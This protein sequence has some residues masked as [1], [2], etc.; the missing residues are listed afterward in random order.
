MADPERADQVGVG[1]ES[2]VVVAGVERRLDEQG[3]LYVL[4][5]PQVAVD[6]VPFHL[7]RGRG[8]AP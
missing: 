5:H 6:V 3:G 7:M 2:M 8:C 4:E 1:L